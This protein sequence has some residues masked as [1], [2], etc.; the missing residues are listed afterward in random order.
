VSTVT[1]NASDFANPAAATTDE[2]AAA[3]NRGIGAQATAANVGGRLV[4]RSNSGGSAATLALA[5]VGA[6]TALAALGL[7]TAAVTGQ[8][9]GVQVTME[10]SYDGSSNGRLVFVPSGDGQIGVTH[11]LHVNVLD[12]R[13]SLVT[14]LDVGAGYDPGKPLALGNGLS[15]SFGPG[16]V[17]ASNGN[18][19]AT[20]VLADS[21]TTDVLV[22]L[23]MNSFFHGSGAGDIA[24][25]QD[26]TLNADGLAA[27]LG[28]AASDGG[29]LAR[30]KTLQETKL[31]DLDGSTAE[32]F[33]AHVVGDV[34]FA[35][36]GATKALDTQNQ[37]LSHLQDE[38]ESVSGVNLDEE[39]LDVTRYQQS[40]EAAS[41]FLTT[42]QSM[43]QTL[44]DIGT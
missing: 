20:D 14:T 8:D 42:V 35:S 15:V 3:I 9:T 17:S 30:L 37:L 12:E 18:V 41:R 22:A 26:L 2:L 25:N 27:G 6:G 1:L 16:S 39:M 36:A 7:G 23:G 33:W 4:I 10:G 19:F 44:L 38:R 31:G 5:N 29:N 24:V 13:G 34:G 28:P 40:F 43:T 21:D 32:D 11:D